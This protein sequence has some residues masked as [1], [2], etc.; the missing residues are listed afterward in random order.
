MEELHLI[1]TISDL[2]PCIGPLVVKSISAT[3]QTADPIV[4]Y[5]QRATNSAWLL[6]SCLECLS[7]RKTSEWKEGVDLDAWATVIVEKWS[8]CGF[9]LAGLNQLI[10]NM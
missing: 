6:G 10:R 4:D 9:V 3:L 2:L 7:K 8:W 1:L 5:E